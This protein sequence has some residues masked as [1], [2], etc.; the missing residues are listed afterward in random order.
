VG[1]ESRSRERWTD[2][3]RERDLDMWSSLGIGRVQ[4]SCSTNRIVLFRCGD[5]GA[6]SSH[7]VAENPIE[8]TVVKR[9]KEVR[10]LVALLKIIKDPKLILILIE[11]I[12][13][14]PTFWRNNNETP[15]GESHQER[16]VDLMKLIASCTEAMSKG[17]QRELLS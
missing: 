1:H 6:S 9:C 2:R 14:Q 10:S 8:G 3:D 11:A 5:D 4:C 15:R 12:F 17:D 16:G 13:I 7:R